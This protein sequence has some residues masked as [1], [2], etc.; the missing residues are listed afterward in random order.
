MSDAILSGVSGLLAHQTM[1]D[2][3][4]DN[5]ANVNTYGYKASRVTFS[6]LLAQTMREA[7][8]PTANVGGTNP[9][10]V[11]GGVKVASIDRNMSQGNM[12][13]TGQP[14]DMAIEGNGYFGLND[15][16]RNVYTRVGAFAVDAD[17]YLVDPGTGYRVQRIGSE[18]VTEGFQ[19]PSSNDIRIPY[20]IALPAKATSTVTFTGNLSADSSASPTACLLTSGIQYT[21]GKA[22][23]ASDA[24]LVDLD[25]AKSVA[26]GDTIAITGTARDGTAVSTVFTIAAASTLGDLATAITAAF[27][28]SQAS[29]AN[30]EIRLTDT[31]SGYSQADMA[32]AYSGS[33]TFE[34]PKYFK[35]L[36]AGGEETRNTNVEIYDSQGTGHVL[37]IAFVRSD[38]PNTW[39]A[40]LM[41]TSGDVQFTGRRV[42]G[43]TFGADG[44]YAGISGG[45]K[46]MF[47][48]KY[49]SGATQDLSLNLGTSGAFDG[50]SQFGGSSTLSASGQDGYQAGYLSSVSVGQ[51]GVLSGMFTNGVRETIAAL[52]LA[53]FQNAAGL[54]SAAGGFFTPSAN[55]GDPVPTKAQSG[56]AGAVTGGS[57]E[58][59]NVDMAREFVS[60]IEAQ[61][62]YQANARTIRTANDM[63]SQLVTLMR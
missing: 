16:Q 14:L 31:T 17:F 44:S 45:S 62:G 36:Q 53:T 8:Q 39:D 48:L 18:G 32:L 29:I 56:G 35:V 26:A 1:L 38:Q 7:T 13:A 24:K 43:I 41:S 9:Q 11:G 4:G 22:I 2:V 46:A 20:D 3:A 6:E 59:S 42:K 30:G 33:G 63:L 21:D 27:S 52:Q 25:Q 58:K 61:N 28:G 19:N 54:Q 55:S 50:L 15:G 51:D 40:V 34:L 60:L 57:L 37:S 10:Q 5:L 23:A 47:T 12:I 49:G